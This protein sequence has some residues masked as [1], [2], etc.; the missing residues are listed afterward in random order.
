M[1]LP[2]LISG[3]GLGG[4]CLAQALKNNIP[5]KIFERFGRGNI[6]AQGYRLRI[7][8][9]CVSAMEEA[10]TPEMFSLFGKTCASIPKLGVKIKRDGSSTAPFGLS[11]GAPGGRSYTVDRSVF[12]EA[13]LTGLEENTLFDNCLK[14]FT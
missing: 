11:P 10:L 6:G 5:F 14:S 8:T 13:L 2:V 9:H 12:R 1:T 7:T 4:V 3:A